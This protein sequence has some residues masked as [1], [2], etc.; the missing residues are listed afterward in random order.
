M[1]NDGVDV[2]HCLRIL[3]IRNFLATMTAGDVHSFAAK[4]I[5]KLGLGE[6]GIQDDRHESSAFISC[7][8]KGWERI[9]S[10]GFRIVAFKATSVSCSH[11]LSGHCLAFIIR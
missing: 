11:S 6:R 1:S 4:G 9:Y 10:R 3:Q 2:S 8:E 7:E 5:I